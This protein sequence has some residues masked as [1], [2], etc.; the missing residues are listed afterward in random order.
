MHSKGGM[1]LLPSILAEQETLKQEKTE[2]EWIEA[3]AAD[4]EQQA[5]R[6]TAHTIYGKSIEEL[7]RQYQKWGGQREI[8][9]HVWNTIMVEEIGEI[10]KALLDQDV[11]HA[12]KEIVQ[13]VTCLVQ[14]Y[15]ALKEADWGETW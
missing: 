7:F 8:T 12:Q 5:L 4:V 3:F 15:H 13:A 9:P 14:L 2:E 10:A 6:T 1:I 11:V